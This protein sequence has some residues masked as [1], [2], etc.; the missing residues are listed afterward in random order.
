MA[1]P[2][3]QFIVDDDGEKKG[4]ILDMAEYRH[5]M[6]EAEELEAIRAYDA[7]KAAGGEAIPFDQDHRARRS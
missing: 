2:R 4:V 1:T 3:H 5:L 6:E 7:A